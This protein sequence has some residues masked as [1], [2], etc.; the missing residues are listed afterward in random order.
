MT[1]RTAPGVNGPVKPVSDPGK[2]RQDSRETTDAAIESIVF[3][4]RCVW[5]ER[6]EPCECRGG[7][8][9]CSCGR[10]MFDGPLPDDGPLAA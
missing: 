4:N 2:H 10:C 5:C 6:E 7:P 8:C 1:L 3:G 9:A